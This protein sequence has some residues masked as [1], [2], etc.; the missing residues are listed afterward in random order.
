MQMKVLIVD[1]LSGEAVTSLEKMN[2]QVEEPNDL[3]AETLPG[4][5]GDT[6]ILIVRSTKVS[7][8]A[9][10]AAPQLSLII[11][12]GAAVDTVDLA[13]ASARGIYVAN[14]PGRTAAAVAE[15]TIGLL[16]AADR[17][18]VDATVD[19]R[20]GAW[21]NGEYG[22]AR[23]LAGR[24][25]GILGF[26]AVGKAVARRAAGLEMNV[27]AWSRSLTPEDRRR[28]SGG[29]CGLA[30][31][32]GRRL[33]RRDRTPG[34]RPG[35]QAVGGQEVSRRDEARRDPDQH[36]PRTDRRYGGAVGG[37]RG[38]GAARR[39][40]RV[41]KRADRRRGRVHRPASWRRW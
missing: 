1:K 31:G 17:R 16:V 9:I 35:N 23:G 25:L 32:P 14:C 18:I 3:N 38:E 8:A 10:E 22:K 34:L 21:R 36:L 28:A 4:D 40:R 39:A 26:G 30:P 20:R 2:L 27:I 6:N 37:D 7:A 24:T 5:L 19:L 29:I 13:A 11:C 33:G 12:A 41:R 15:L